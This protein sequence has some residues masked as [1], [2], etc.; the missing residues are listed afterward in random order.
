[1]CSLLYVANKPPKE[2]F[3]NSELNDEVLKSHHNH[4]HHQ[5]HH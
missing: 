3:L 1:M 5:H 4:K 2:V